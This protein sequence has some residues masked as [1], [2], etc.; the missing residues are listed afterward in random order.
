MLIPPILGYL[1]SIN[2]YPPLLDNACLEH[3]IRIH[4]L[5]VRSSKIVKEKLL[6]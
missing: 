4:K 1:V 6:S 3:E 2:P 5:Y